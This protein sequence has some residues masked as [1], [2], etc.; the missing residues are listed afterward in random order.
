MFR[1]LL[2]GYFVFGLGPFGL[3]LDGSELLLGR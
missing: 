3:P 2:Q 1:S